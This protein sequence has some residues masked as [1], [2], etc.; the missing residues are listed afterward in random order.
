MK[1][2]VFVILIFVLLGAI[3]FVYVEVLVKIMNGMLVG[4]NQMMFYIFD[5]DVVGSGKFVCN[6]FCVI[7]WL[8][9]MVVDSD[10][11][12][13]DFIVIMCDDGKK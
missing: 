3:V 8:L 13:G 2:F 5:K 11:F 12:S 1:F 6:G 9:F 4:F 10:Q 7:N